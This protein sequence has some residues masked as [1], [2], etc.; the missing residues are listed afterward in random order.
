MVEKPG[1]REFLYRSA[2][3]SAA[4]SAA[5]LPIF[6]PVL[7]LAAQ[8]VDPA[9]RRTRLILL[10]TSAGSPPNPV[11][12]AAASCILVDGIP[13][14]IDCGDGVARQ[15][16]KAGISLTQAPFI[17]ITHHHSDH[18]AGYGNLLQ[19][20]A[21]AGRRGQVNVFGP[22][23][24]RKMT[25]QFFDMIRPEMEN[26][27]KDGV[28]P[29]EHDIVV[30][31]VSNEGLVHQDERIRVTAAL[32]YH[33]P[34]E[35][36]FAFRFDSADRSITF[37]GDTGYSENLIK[38]AK[39]T[40]VL[41]H[42]VQHMAIMEESVRRNPRGRDVALFLKHMRETHTSPEDAGKVATLSN[43]KMLVFSHIG[44]QTTPP[45]P[46]QVFIDAARTTFSG[47]IVV[48]QDLMEI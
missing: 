13:Y 22:P 38:L 15:M 25:A 48:G 47:K 26:R 3:A 14:I 12:S 16:A 31:E 43:A 19:L 29:Y 1:R 37:S 36:A 33:A 34:V 6:A 17:F 5:A 11:R 42:E 30:H 32:V 20:G 46:D 27:I 7:E 28:R 41:V 35:P 18:T 40:D 10:G 4:A 21:G 24:L 39:D 44:P 45:V 8:E 2:L 23:P 9:K